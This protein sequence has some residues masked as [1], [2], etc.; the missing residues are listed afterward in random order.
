[1]HWLATQAHGL[2]SGLKTIHKLPEPGPSE[3][4]DGKLYGIHGDL[5]PE[6]ILH[7]SQETDIH[8]FGTLKIADFGIV[9]FRSWA[10]KTSPNE[11]WEGPASPTYRAPEHDLYIH[12]MMSRKVDI[13][14]MGCVFSEMFTWAL[15]GGN[16]V[17]TYRDARMTDKTRLAD[18]LSWTEDN[19][20]CRTKGGRLSDEADRGSQYDTHIVKPSV[21]KVRPL[22]P[23]WLMTCLTW[24]QWLADLIKLCSR[25]DV[26]HQET[27]CEEFLEFIRDFMLVPVREARV[28]CQDVIDFVEPRLK[29]PFKEGYWDCKLYE[30]TPSVFDSQ[31]RNVE[32]HSDDLHGD[33]WTT[34]NT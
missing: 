1:M 5:K 24:Y 27:F 29:A 25:P 3:A 26:P 32:V 20:F 21:R 11:E 17:E 4:V 33:D 15:L 9:E 30:G 18:P 23:Y 12:Q 34:A 2:M 16:A 14:S 31:L 6:N 28:T 22:L 7:F 19:F 13:W 10:T 8:Q